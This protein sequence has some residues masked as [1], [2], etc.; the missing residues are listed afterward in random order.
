MGLPRWSPTLDNVRI[1]SVFT[2]MA[3]ML[4]KS[5]SRNVGVSVCRDL[6]KYLA[7]EGNSLPSTLSSCPGLTGSGV[8]LSEA[9]HCLTSADTVSYW[10]CCR[11]S[12]TLLTIQ[13]CLESCAWQRKNQKQKWIMKCPEPVGMVGGVLLCCS[14]LSPSCWF[15]LSCFG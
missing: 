8:Y 1:L 3:P 15:S 14:L 12:G 6:P 11:D 5:Y 4:I 7:S 9:L 13:E 2:E 10:P